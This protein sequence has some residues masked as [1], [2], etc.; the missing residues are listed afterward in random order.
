MT[1]LVRVVFT[2]VWLVITAAVITYLWRISADHAHRV[3][4]AL[5]KLL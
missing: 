2:L 5:L 4:V 3:K 1:V